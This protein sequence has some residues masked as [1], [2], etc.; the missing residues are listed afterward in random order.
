MKIDL[1]YEL[2]M[3]KPWGPNAEYNTYWEAMEQI[4]A[5]DRCGFDT[6]WEVEHHFLEEYSHSSAPEVFLSAVAQ[7]TKNI[8]IGHGVVL[9]PGEFNHPIRVAERVAVLD[10]MSKGRLEFGTGR[11]SVYEQMGFGIDPT[12]SREMWQEAVRIIPQMWLQEKFSYEGRFLKIPERAVIPKPVQK[13]HPPMWV[14]A[15]GIDTWELAGANGLGCL[16]LTIWV[17]LP[18][19]EQRMA[20]YHK[21]LERCRP[22]GA[23]INNKVGVFTIAHCA[24]SLNT[25]LDQGAV[26]GAMF[27][28]MKTVRALASTPRELLGKIPGT[29]PYE[30]LLKQF[31]ALKRYEEQ[32]RLSFDEI[33]ERDMIIV[34]DPD[35][36][37]AKLKRY[38]KAGADHVLCLMQVGSLKHPHIM[39]SIELFGKYVIPEFRNGKPP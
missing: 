36:C 39:K 3:P 28:V 31:P 25:A 33:N 14:A 4:E 18:E 2:E 29:L 30:D 38:E 20:R 21:A 35:Q 9:L 15:T 17:D 16:G 23:F 1:V 12:L 26:D 32:G 22:A 6:V 24:E 27:H 10:I 37:V 5:A 34:G 11:S 7:R 13:P 19:L 8:R